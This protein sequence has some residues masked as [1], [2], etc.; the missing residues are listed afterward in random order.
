VVSRLARLFRSFRR[1][2]TTSLSGHLDCT[3]SLRSPNIAVGLS[4]SVRR[5][6]RHAVQVIRA[7]ALH[8]LRTRLE[9]NGSSCLDLSDNSVPEFLIPGEPGFSSGGAAMIDRR[10]L[11][12]FPGMS[13]ADRQPQNPLRLAPCAGLRF[14]HRNQQ[15]AFAI[16]SNNPLFRAAARV[17]LFGNIGSVT[18]AVSSTTATGYRLAPEAPA[19]RL[20]CESS[21]L[22]LRAPQKPSYTVLITSACRTFEKTLRLPSCASRMK[23]GLR[24]SSHFRADELAGFRRFILT[25]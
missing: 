14:P 9:P 20:R 1:R 2:R 21:E 23:R 16:C 13:S 3:T 5:D 11:P 24:R 15:N 22:R 12:G 17:F 18:V 7:F 6:L 8:D 25:G 4:P 19:R 10:L